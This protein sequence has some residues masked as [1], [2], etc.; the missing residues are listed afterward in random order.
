MILSV[1]KEWLD[2]YKIGVLFSTHLTLA[3]LKWAQKYS[4]LNYTAT[5][6]KK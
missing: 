2:A 4:N 1:L 6:Y 3:N 5:T